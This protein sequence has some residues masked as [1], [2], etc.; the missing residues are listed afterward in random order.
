MKNIDTLIDL[1]LTSDDPDRASWGKQLLR[2]TRYD[3]GKFD[4]LR[5]TVKPELLC[6][7][8]NERREIFHLPDR[9]CLFYCDD[10]LFIHLLSCD[11]GVIEARAAIVSECGKGFYNY[12]V[13]L[14]ISSDKE[15]S[16]FPFLNSKKQKEKI[17]K[18]DAKWLFCMLGMFFVIL[19]DYPEKVKKD[20][21][22]DIALTM[23][24]IAVI[25]GITLDELKRRSEEE[26]WFANMR[27]RSGNAHE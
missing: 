12:P 7:Y 19:H 18:R 24:G 8:L 13:Y 15:V 26:H 1:M 16:H 5:E 10:F 11:D 17:S 22:M 3:F 2:A 27:K 23:E 14:N 9:N 25:T 4:S 21:I 20:S 6:T